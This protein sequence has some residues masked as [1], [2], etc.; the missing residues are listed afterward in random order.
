MEV[1]TLA[2]LGHLI[3]KERMTA[4]Q[5]VEPIPTVIANGRYGAFSP[6]RH[7]ISHR[8]QSAPIAATGARR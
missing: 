5:P 1:L 2:H 7:V 4:S 3:A 8:L 6:I